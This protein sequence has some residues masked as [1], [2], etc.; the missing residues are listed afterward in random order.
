[1]AVRDVS[2]PI[3]L[4]GSLA[5]HGVLLVVFARQFPTLSPKIEP[6]PTLWIDET[7]PPEVSETLGNQESDG[8]ATDSSPGE[9]PQ[10]AKL[11]NQEQAMLSLD[12][13]GS[14]RKS[15][16]AK[17]LSERIDETKPID[18]PAMEAAI[19]LTERSQFH[20]PYRPKRITPGTGDLRPGQEDVKELPTEETTEVSVKPNTDPTPSPKTEEHTQQE[21]S[22]E[23]NPISPQVPSVASSEGTPIPQG[24]T[25]SDS[26][27]E[28]ANVD[29][30]V[31]KV[32]ART[33]RPHRI[34][35]PREGLSG[36]IDAFSSPGMTLTLR[37]RLS[38]TGDVTDV[39]IVR[40]SGSNSIDQPWKVAAYSW[41]FEP[42]KDG[43]GHSIEDIVQLTLRFM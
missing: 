28:E 32:I 23:T 35:R 6:K 42:K 10:L 24:K 14:G 3:A 9:L 12:P 8:K 15:D 40:S 4:I 27:S 37:L 20:E 11:N 31:G 17:P 33:G 36:M 39:S 30:R 25:E 1:M 38:P 7:N 16:A 29:V 18:T 22:A 41:W 43:T 19:G 13:T 5:L 34:T 26:F 2:F 21:P